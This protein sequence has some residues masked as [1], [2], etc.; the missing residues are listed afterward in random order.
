MSYVLIPE[1][2]NI[3]LSRGKCVLSGESITSFIDADQKEKAR[4]RQESRRILHSHRSSRRSQVKSSRSRKSTE[5]EALLKWS[6]ILG[7]SRIYTRYIMYRIARCR[8]KEKKIY[9]PCLMHS[10]SSQKMT[11]KCFETFPELSS[12][13]Q[14]EK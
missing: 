13:S 5:M 6:S 7:F 10:S 4:R 8:A 1:P 2:E 12:E 14:S 11:V 3:P 9:R